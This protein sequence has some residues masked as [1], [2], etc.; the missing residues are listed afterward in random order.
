MEAVNRTASISWVHT[1][2]GVTEDIAWEV[3]EE[4]VLVSNPIL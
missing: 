1:H 4:L 2:V 3:T